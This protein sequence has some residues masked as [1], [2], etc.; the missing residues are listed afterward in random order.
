MMRRLLPLLLLL[1]V[2]LVMQPL[3]PMQLSEFL[4][5]SSQYCNVDCIDKS[6]FVVGDPS[7]NR[8]MG[9]TEITQSGVTIH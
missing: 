1:L 2:L 4:C 7:A 3:L 6:N 5:F 8:F 9:Y